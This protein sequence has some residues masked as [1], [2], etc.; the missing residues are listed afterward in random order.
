M[1]ICDDYLSDIKEAYDTAVFG[2]GF[3]FEPDIGWLL[4]NYTTHSEFDYDWRR[5]VT[6]AINSLA[7]VVGHILWGNNSY[8]QPERVPYYLEHCVGGDAAEVTMDAILTAMITADFD[9][10]QK[11]V[12]LSDAYRTAIWNQPFNAEFYAALARGFMP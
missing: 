7:F 3:F 10:L 1:A 12:G 4:D 8:N 6:Y 2:W 11:F 9:E 5:Y